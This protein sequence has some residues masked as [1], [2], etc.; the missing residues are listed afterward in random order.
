MVRPVADDAKT[1][2]TR[3][4]DGNQK[5]AVMEKGRPEQIDKINFNP[6]GRKTIFQKGKADTDIFKE[7]LDAVQK[8]QD[9]HAAYYL[10]DDDKTRIGYCDSGD[11]LS[12]DTISWCANRN[13]R[14][15][16]T[17]KPCV[18]PGCRTRRMPRQKRHGR[19]RVGRRTL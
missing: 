10:T 5:E 8:F 9:K 6:T 12:W 1:G 4:R 19:N 14:R 3:R 2:R 7:N 11:H 15:E 17:R 13:C 18:K 16:P